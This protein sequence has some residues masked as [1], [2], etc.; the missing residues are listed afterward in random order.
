MEAL[1]DAVVA[2][3]APHGDDLVGPGGE[4]VA[5][6]HELRQAGLAQLVDCAQEARDQDLALPAGANAFAGKRIRFEPMITCS[7]GRPELPF[8]SSVAPQTPAKGAR[9]S[10]C[11]CGASRCTILSR[12]RRKHAAD[13]GF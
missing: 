4:S 10:G 13:F 12:F 3:E 8:E 7:H 11:G 9:G 6:L 2:S 1:A 5:Q